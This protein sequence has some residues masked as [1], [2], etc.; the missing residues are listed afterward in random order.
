MTAADEV[1]DV[2]ELLVEAFGPDGWRLVGMDDA[3]GGRG[4]FSRV[5]RVRLAWTDGA[6]GPGS[7]IVKLPAAG[8]NGDAARASGAYRREALAYRQLL[9]G[10]P[11]ATPAVHHVRLVDD[12]VSLVL[13]D[14]GAERAVDQMEGL[15]PNDALSVGLELTRLHHHWRRSPRLTGLAI[16]RST[17]AALPAEA[18]DAG[19]TALRQRWSA[20]VDADQRRAFDDLVAARP[21]VVDA[22]GAAGPP[23][24]CHGD[25][26]AD[27]LVFRDPDRAV[28][29]D[30]QQVAIQ[31]GAAD[32]AWL[33]ATSLRPDVRRATEPTLLAECDTPIDRYRLGLVLPGL[34]VLLLAQRRATDR[35]TERFIAT[36]LT[37]IGQALVDHEL[38]RVT[39]G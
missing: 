12:D 9:P 20:D 19:L 21:A 5:L 33:A 28:L 24:L 1:R 27:N 8:P 32:L 16:R 11:V 14:L 4:V 39:I 13:E 3:A 34:A 6:D 30:W 31:F 25:P 23:T 15:S 2:G 26:R 22:F 29:F 36:S 37:R 18:L 10:T 17:P 38:P 35:R 7:V